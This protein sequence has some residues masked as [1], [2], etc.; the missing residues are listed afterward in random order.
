VQ[1]E[2]ER[3]MKMKKFSI[4]LEYSPG[5]SQKLDNLL[6][7][8]AKKFGGALTDSGCFLIGDRLRDMRFEFKTKKL[9]NDF[10]E[11]VEVIRK[12][13]KAGRK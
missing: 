4:E 11:Q 12:K 5:I 8:T 10:Y 2:T 13:Q 1:E 7:K 9:A 3:G 6:I